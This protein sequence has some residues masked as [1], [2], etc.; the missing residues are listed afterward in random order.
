MPGPDLTFVEIYTDGMCRGNL[1]PGGWGALLRFAG[2]ENEISG[3]E[4]D[5]ANNRME[6]TAAIAALEMLK[7]SVKARIH[8]NSVTQPGHLGIGSLDHFEREAV[9][10]LH[11]TFR[12][13]TIKKNNL[14]SFI[15]T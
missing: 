10:T 12:N 15:R 9:T 13:L 5:T 7:C 2:I 4:A 6:L 11:A 14:M 1:G 3:G 8:T